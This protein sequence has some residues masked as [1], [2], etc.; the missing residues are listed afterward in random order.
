MIY[1][2]IHD[3]A[4]DQQSEGGQQQGLSAQVTSGPQVRPHL[5]H[6]LVA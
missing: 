2:S 5:R 3:F 1:L 4:S 6:R